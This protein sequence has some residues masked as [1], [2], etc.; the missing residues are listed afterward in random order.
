[1]EGYYLNNFIVQDFSIDK[2]LDR[3]IEVQFKETP[4]GF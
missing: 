1:M 2:T 3:I 4:S